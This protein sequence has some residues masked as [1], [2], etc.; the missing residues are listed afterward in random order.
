M[1]L[2]GTGFAQTAADY[3]KR[4]ADLIELATIFGELHH[5]RRMCEPRYE[6]DVWRE[7]MKML[8][9]LEQPQFDAREAMVKG[10]N[11]GFRGAGSRFRRCSRNAR[12]FAAGRA[13]QGE[14]ITD[15][16]TRNLEP[17]ETFGQ[18][19]FELVPQDN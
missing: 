1:A 7:R 8:I 18:D 15:R 9:E 6:A 10:F 13:L 4:N 5:I 2:T 11:R 17:E 16:L 19:G 14:E 3:R 12:D